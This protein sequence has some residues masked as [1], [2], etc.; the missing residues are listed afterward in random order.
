MTEKKKLTPVL[1]KKERYLPRIAIINQTETE[2]AIRNILINEI[3]DYSQVDPSEIEPEDKRA[4]MDYH[5]GKN[6]PLKVI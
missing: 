2:L 4:I 5:I 3:K 1:V 6:T